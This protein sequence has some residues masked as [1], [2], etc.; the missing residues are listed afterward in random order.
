MA[1]KLK[2]RRFV[3]VYAEC[4]CGAKEMYQ[5]STETAGIA[6]ICGKGFSITKHRKGSATVECN[7]CIQ[8]R[9]N[10]EIERRDARDKLRAEIAERKAALKSLNSATNGVPV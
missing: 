8:K 7:Q 1:G 5:G 3:E 2:T 9:L 4:A 10:A 6:T